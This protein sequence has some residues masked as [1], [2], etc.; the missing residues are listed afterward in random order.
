M[1]SDTEYEEPDKHDGKGGRIKA[2]KQYSYSAQDVGQS[3]LP[4]GTQ[5]E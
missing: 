5:K 2:N 4:S 1:L 3:R